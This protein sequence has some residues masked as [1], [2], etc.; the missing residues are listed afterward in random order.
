MIFRREKVEY[1]KQDI[2]KGIIIPE[3][4]T[5]E[6]AE[7]IG[8]I[9]GD[10]YLRADF[11]DL[12]THSYKSDVYI[13]CNMKEED[14]IDYIKG[15]FKCIFNYDLKSHDD[16]RS[17]AVN[18]VAHSRAIVSFLCS[19]CDLPSGRKVDTISVPPM[20]MHSCCSVKASF[21]RGLAASDFSLTFQNRNGKGYTYPVIKGHFKSALLVRDIEKLFKEFGI[22][23]S[24]CLRERLYD[25]RISKHY[26]M[27][28]IYIYG[29]DNLKSWIDSI[30]FSNPK[31]IYKLRKWQE[32]GYCPPGY[33][34]SLRRD[35]Q[36]S[37]D[38]KA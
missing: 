7:L 25:K 30:G 5:P 12:M 28:G 26:H 27:A 37:L 20:I 18:L 29:K 31:F 9:V 34:E 38:I 10:G 19:C 21:L 15:L 33:I 17:N 23:C 22:S 35:M 4:L 6:L 8:M 13:S 24:I 14:F 16:K 2:R 11:L 3:Q 1:S 32:D 36:T